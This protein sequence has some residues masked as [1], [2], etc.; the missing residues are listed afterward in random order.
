MFI[1]FIFIRKP[2]MTWNLDE[3]AKNFTGMYGLSI[4][5]NKFLYNFS[6]Q[7]PLYS[8]RGKE[9]APSGEQ[10]IS[11]WNIFNKT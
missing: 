2:A 9:N 11:L 4:F 8:L 7:I 6:W 5:W 10:Y 3:Q 1:S